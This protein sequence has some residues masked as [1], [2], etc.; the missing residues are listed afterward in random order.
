MA[1]WGQPTAPGAIT[2]YVPFSSPELRVDDDAIG[3]ALAQPGPGPLGAAWR[4]ARSGTAPWAGPG[5]PA[6]GRTRRGL[7]AYPAQSN[8]S[9]VQHPLAWIQTAHELGYDVLLD[10]IAWSILAAWRP[11]QAVERPSRTSQLSGGLCVSYLARRTG[12]AVINPP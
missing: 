1:S 6:A 11:G 9:G 3:Q 2:Q 12:H 8:F 5:L 10:G 4:M 7:L